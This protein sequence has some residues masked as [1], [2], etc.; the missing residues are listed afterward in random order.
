[1][2]AAL[3]LNQGRRGPSYPRQQSRGKRGLVQDRRF[4]DLVGMSWR[5]RILSRRQYEKTV[6]EAVK[7]LENIGRNPEA[8]PQL[9]QRA[10]KVIPLVPRRP[11]LPQA[12]ELEPSVPPV[13]PQA[14]A[15]PAEPDYEAMV[16]NDAKVKE[17]AALLEWAD[18]EDWLLAFVANGGGMPL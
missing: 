13:N 17:I 3:L 18:E 6:R 15:P 7:R 5:E 8:V 14:V 10:R 4:V 2:L 9:Q 11:V 12:P 1:M 16:R